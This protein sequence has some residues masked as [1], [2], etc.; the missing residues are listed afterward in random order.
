MR[1]LIRWLL[2][3]AWEKINILNT[4]RE[5][6]ALGKKYGKRFFWAALIW[7]CIEDIVFPFIAWKMGVPGLI[8]VFLVMH[9][10]PVVYPVLFWAF[11][12]W[13][14][15]QG[16]EP[17][18]PNRTAYSHHWRSLLKGLTFQLA[19]TG[20]LGHILSWKLLAVYTALQ[21]TFGFVHDR[22]W[23]DSN[24]GILGNDLVQYRRP[25][26]KTATYLLLT[27]FVLY[28]LLRLMHPDTLGWL[29]LEAQ[30]ITAVLFL[31][32]ETVWAKSL[33]GIAVSHS[34]PLDHEEHR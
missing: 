6:K 4:W 15:I 10:E 16:K 18:E 7:E 3:E 24:Y 31:V 28:P 25:I 13:D 5:I 30:G 21:A 22:I 20:W 11:R 9:F 26:A 29:L 2:H 34:Q 17:W 27:T 12:T 1:S 23:H 33:W 8:P 32:L 19:L 14:R